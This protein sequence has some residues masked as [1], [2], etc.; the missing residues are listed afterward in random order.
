[1]NISDTKI[2]KSGFSLCSFWNFPGVRSIK[3]DVLELSVGFIV[4]GDQDS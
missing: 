2:Y 1:M 3:A 4:L